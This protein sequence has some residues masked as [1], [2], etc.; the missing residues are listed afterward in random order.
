MSVCG[1]L[2][3]NLGFSAHNIEWVLSFPEREH[4]RENVQGD[5]VGT[6][7]APKRLLLLHRRKMID[8]ENRL[9]ITM[10]LKN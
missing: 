6:S 5:S 1:L 4:Q 8:C 9:E 7:N 10:K 3:R 2:S